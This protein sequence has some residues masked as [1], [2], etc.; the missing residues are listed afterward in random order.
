MKQELLTDALGTLDADIIG[1]YLA[2]EKKLKKRRAKRFV[3]A[4]AACLAFV[5][6]AIPVVSVTLK[7][8]LQ[9]PDITSEGTENPDPPRWMIIA[10]KVPCGTV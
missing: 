1:D 5:I 9:P 8:Q 10:I 2:T 4:L 7:H 6:V 3:S